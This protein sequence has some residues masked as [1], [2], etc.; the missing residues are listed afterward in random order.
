[1]KTTK[2][3]SKLK[4]LKEFELT[5][6]QQ[7]KVNGGGPWLFVVAPLVNINIPVGGVNNDMD[8]LMGSD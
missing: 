3:T 6:K 1:M 5:S 2:K 7:S 4:E 8:G